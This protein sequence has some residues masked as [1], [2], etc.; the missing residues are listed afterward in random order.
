[1]KR[2]VKRLFRMLM[3]FRKMVSGLYGA[4]RLWYL[5]IPL[6]IYVVKRSHRKERRKQVEDQARLNQWCRSVVRE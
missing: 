3:G 6:V 2:Q 1:M 4:R 5:A